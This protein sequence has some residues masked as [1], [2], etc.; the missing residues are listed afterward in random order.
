[1]NTIFTDIVFHIHDVRGRERCKASLDHPQDIVLAEI[2]AQNPK[3]RQEILRVPAH[4]NRL[5]LLCVKG[6][7]GGG[8]REREKGRKRV[9]L[10]DSNRHILP[11]NAVAVPVDQRLAS[12]LAFQI[13]ILGVINPHMGHIRYLGAVQIRHCLLLCRGGRRTDHDF[14]ILALIDFFTRKRAV[15]VNALLHVGNAR[16]NG[17]KHGFPLQCEGIVVMVEVVCQSQDGVIRGAEN[18]SIRANVITD[19]TNHNLGCSTIGD[20]G[21]NKIQNI[22]RNIVKAVDQKLGVPDQPTPADMVNG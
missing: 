2:Q 13:G 22:M 19:Q 5:I 6:N 11:R 20:S 16:I 17:G 21:L 7:P 10:T 9:L 12:M 14:F 8:K 1:M 4:Q 18:L 15:C 3:K